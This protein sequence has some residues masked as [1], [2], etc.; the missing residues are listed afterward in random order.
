MH[1]ALALHSRLAELGNGTIQSIE[2]G[3]GELAIFLNFF[4][5]GC[6]YFSPVTCLCLGG[7]YKGNAALLEHILRSFIVGAVDT[8][9]P[10]EDLT[11]TTANHRLIRWIQLLKLITLHHHG[12]EEVD[13][14]GIVDVF[15]LGVPLKCNGTHRGG[16]DRVD[17]AGLQI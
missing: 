2:D 10:V 7:V 6:C 12:A 13:E 9:K 1:G 5:S 17:H 3:G 8:I 11:H 14:W 16:G 15:H 4:H